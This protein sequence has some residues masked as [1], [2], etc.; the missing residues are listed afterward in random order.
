VLQI[1]PET[2]IPLGGLTFDC[3]WFTVENFPI[4]WGSETNI[5]LIN[6]FWL[7]PYTLTG[8]DC[9]FG[10]TSGVFECDALITIA[11]DS[12]IGDTWQITL[13]DTFDDTPN[14]DY[15]FGAGSLIAWGDDLDAVLATKVPEPTA[16]VLLSLGLAGLGFARRKMKA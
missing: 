6:D 5:V 11:Q 2:V 8:S 3:E 12:L 1:K 4:S 9:G 16:L 10:D 15:T 13:S 7:T 14:P